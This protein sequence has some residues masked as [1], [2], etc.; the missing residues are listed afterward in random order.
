MAGKETPG[1]L[2]QRR[3]A[4]DRVAGRHALVK[5]HVGELLA[6]ARPAADQL[7]QL[8]VHHQVSKPQAAGLDAHTRERGRQL[9]AGAWLALQL[10]PQHLGAAPEQ[11]VV[12]LELA[13]PV[14]VGDM[15]ARRCEIQDPADIGGRHEMP[16]RS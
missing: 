3:I 1:E 7:L 5:Q 4:L 14:G 15:N 9:G 13:V 12:Q 6:A 2:G 10:G 16:G 11:R 8:G